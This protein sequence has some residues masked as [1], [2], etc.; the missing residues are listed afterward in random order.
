[1]ICNPLSCASP[2][3]TECEFDCW[4]DIDTEGLKAEIEQ[5]R[6]F[7]ADF[8]PAQDALAGKNLLK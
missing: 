6:I 8:S 5:A 2:E 1:M 4:C 3:G 7:A